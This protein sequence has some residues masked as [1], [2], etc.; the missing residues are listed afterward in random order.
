MQISGWQVRDRVPELSQVD[1]KLPQPPNPPH[2]GSS[3]VLPSFIGVL[4]HT[5]V[6]VSHSPVPQVSVKGAQSSL[7]VHP[8]MTC[9]SGSTNGAASVA[10][11]GSS[12]TQV[13]PSPS[14]AALP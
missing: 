6:P 2:I 13:S 8:V 10:D 14:P 1:S 11:T 5:P 12:P 3:H 4:L 7:D 9:A